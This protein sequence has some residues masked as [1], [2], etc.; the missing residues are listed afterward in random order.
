MAGTRHIRLRGRIPILTSIIPN[1][2]ILCFTFLDE[3][4]VRN[5]SRNLTGYFLRMSPPILRSEYDGLIARQ[6]CWRF[7]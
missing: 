5:Q 7:C 1:G 4:P 3:K 6:D 2:P